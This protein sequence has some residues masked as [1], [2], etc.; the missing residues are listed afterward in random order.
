MKN[1]LFPTRQE[2]SFL[3]HSSF[4]KSFGLTVPFLWSLLITLFFAQTCTVKFAVLLPL[5]V[6][7]L[8]SMRD[9]DTLCICP[10]QLETTIHLFIAFFIFSYILLLIL[11]SYWTCQLTFPTFISAFCVSLLMDTFFVRGYFLTTFLESYRCYKE[12][13]SFYTLMFYKLFSSF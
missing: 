8:F 4:S 12:V 2:A 1:E 11:L 3:I 6:F 13:R 9:L 7:A 10:T 5:F